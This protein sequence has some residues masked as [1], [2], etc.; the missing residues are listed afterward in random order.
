MCVV[1]IVGAMDSS[2]AIRVGTRTYFEAP[3]LSSSPVH[4]LVGSKNPTLE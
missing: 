2:G 3:Y 1:A 4:A